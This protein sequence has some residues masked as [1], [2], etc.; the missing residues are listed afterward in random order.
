VN[1]QYPKLVFDSRIARR[2][3]AQAFE[4]GMDSETKRWDLAATCR[5]SAV[6]RQKDGG[7]GDSFI[8]DLVGLVISFVHR[9]RSRTSVTRSESRKTC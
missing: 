8:R 3:L 1:E 9:I 7:D 5:T 6:P 2:R 4:L